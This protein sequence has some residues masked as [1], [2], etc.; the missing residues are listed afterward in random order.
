MC[1]K[2]SANRLCLGAENKLRETFCNIVNLHAQCLFFLQ[3]PDYS[4]EEKSLSGPDATEIT[5]AIL[6]GE[7]SHNLDETVANS[8]AIHSS[9]KSTLFETVVHL[10]DWFASHPSLSKEAFS[11]NLQ[12]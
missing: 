1:G 12:I 2:V 3:G 9:L 10:F 6:S 11:K 7:F 4:K 8:P 5:V